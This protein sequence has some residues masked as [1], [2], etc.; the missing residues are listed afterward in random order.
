MRKVN[1]LLLAASIVAFITQ[2]SNAQTEGKIV[3]QKTLARGDQI[4]EII[5]TSSD[6]IYFVGYNRNNNSGLDHYNITKIDKLSLKNIWVK[7]FEVDFP[8]AFVCNNKLMLLGATN[9]DN[10]IGVGVYASDDK[11]DFSQAVELATP[12]ASDKVLG[13]SQE[14]NTWM[15]KQMLRVEHVFSED[16]SKIM[17]LIYLRS[18]RLLKDP[19]EMYAKILDTKTMT[20]IWETRVPAT[21]KGKIIYTYN[22]KV[23]NDGTLFYMFSYT[24]ND[25]MENVKNVL[26]KLTSKKEENF[27]PIEAGANIINQSIFQRFKKIGSDR[28][29]QRL[30]DC[31]NEMDYELLSDDIL[32][33]YLLKNKLKG[34]KNNCGLFTATLEKDNLKLK[35]KSQEDFPES[36][37]GQLKKIEKKGSAQ[38]DYNISKIIHFKDNSF[39][40]LR[41]LEMSSNSMTYSNYGLLLFKLDGKNKITDSFSLLEP[42]IGGSGSLPKSYPIFKTENT[43]QLAVQMNLRTRKKSIELSSDIFK[44]ISMDIDDNLLFIELSEKGITKVSSYPVEKGFLVALPENNFTRGNSPITVH[45]KG[46]QYEIKLLDIK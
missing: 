20:F 32:V 23:D 41:V 30:I 7:K 19:D 3:K 26:G 14:K 24:Q 1:F 25:D 27:Y 29:G 33:S 40:L 28:A 45:A 39:V 18:R 38:L 12:I 16:S 6:A 10:K 5:G 8:N 31:F 17:L 9:K 15:S 11:G 22:H 4:G 44:D 42:A 13:D 36:I 46:I 43:Y 21:Y 34:E 35:T 2:T 37:E